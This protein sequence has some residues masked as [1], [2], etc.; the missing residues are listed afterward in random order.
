M[1]NLFKKIGST[2]IMIIGGTLVILGTLG[3]FGAITIAAYELHWFLGSIVGCFFMI[4]IGLFFMN[5]IGDGNN[6]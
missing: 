3:I 1:K 6:N 4:V 2:T 5:V